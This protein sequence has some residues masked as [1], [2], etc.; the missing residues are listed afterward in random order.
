ME[1]RRA[2]KTAP[3]SLTR[4]AALF[5][6]HAISTG[7]TTNGLL[8]SRGVTR[9]A[10]ISQ[11][12]SPGGGDDPAL[13]FLSV[14]GA[15][16]PAKVVVNEVTTVASVWTN[17]QFLNGAA[18]KG[19][20]LSLS[21]AAGNVTNFVDLTTGGWGTAIQDSLNSGQTPTMANFATLADV[22]AGCA[23]R[24]TANACDG[25]FVAATPPKGDAPTD[26]LTVAE[27]IARYPWYQ[28]ERL[29]ALLDAFYPVSTGRSMR[30]VPFMPY[31]NFSPSAWV[32]TAEVRRR[33]LS[34]RRQ[35]DVRQ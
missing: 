12:G 3:L 28:P 23:T 6:R 34:R 30:T 33:R 5:S 29:F 27:S 19:P 2:A 35:G 11:Q 15:A 13:D 18:I 22:L 8:G 14:L 4:R 17:A 31:L 26:T 9:A 1:R 7:A 24:V 32:F 25:L 20:P 10:G 21:I 16:P